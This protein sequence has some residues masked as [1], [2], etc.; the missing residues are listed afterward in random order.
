MNLYTFKIVTLTS[1][2]QYAIELKGEMFSNM[3]KSICVNQLP[4]KAQ[5]DN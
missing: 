1:F 2:E 3:G 5:V 4:S